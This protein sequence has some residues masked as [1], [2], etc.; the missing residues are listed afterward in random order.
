VK[1]AL[2]MLARDWRAGELRVLALALAVA[3]AAITSV[4]FFADRVGQSLARD[5]HQLLGADLV[6]RADRP[7]PSA[8]AAA[9]ERAGV[10]RAEAINFISMA[11]A[12]ESHL[13]GVKA[14][15]DNYPLR[16]RLRIASAPGM[17]DAPAERGPA[18]GTVWLEERLVSA[19]GAPVG[20]RIRLGRAEF[21]VAAVLTL[22]PER[23]TSFFN[24][25]PRL[26]M[27]IAD[28]PSTALIQT[29]SRVWY[30]LYAAGP[31]ERIK[32]LQQSIK[33]ERGQSLDT[34]E[35]GRPEV[36]SA[37]DR[38]QRFLGLT[39]LLAAILAGVAVA[40]GTRRFVER[41]LDGC[42]VMRCLGA[43]QSQLLGLYALEF[44]IL[45]VA[46][47]AAGCAIGFVAQEAIAATV[48]EVIRAD[49]PPP[50]LLPAVQGFLVGLVLLLGFALPPLVQLRNVP[51]VR[52]M[53]RESGAPKGGTLV[54]YAAGLISLSSLLVWQAG[55]LKLGLTVVGGFA[56]A[57][58]VFFVVAWMFLKAMTGKRA[59]GLMPN[60][61][62]RYGL[63]NLRR[64]ARS[65]AVQ[66]ASLALGLTA[67]LL[68]T[69]TRND[70]VDAWRRSAPPDAPNRF[71]IG[72]Q[73]EQLEPLQAF[74]A[75]HKVPVPDLYP[76]VRGRLIA[77]N[78]KPVSEADYSEER[79]KRLVEREFNLSYMNDLPGHN[80]VVAGK[81]FDPVAK[82]ISVEQGIAE[83]LGWRLGDE[84]TWSVGSDS[85]SARITSLRKLRWDSMKVNFFVV[86]P[87]A[88]LEGFPVSFISA[89]HLG[90]E[91]QPVITELAARFPNVTV[92]DAAA[93]VRQA[94]DVIDQLI[95]A[96]Q[97]VFLFTLAAGLLV[98]YSA[99]VATEDERRREAAVMRVYGASRAQVTGTQRAE[100]LAMGAIAGLLATLGAAAIG[101]VLARRVFELDLPPSLALWIAGPLAGLALLSLNAWLSSRKVL[102]ASPALTLRDSV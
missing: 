7:W 61:M 67:V 53:R 96:V 55:D 80:Q 24:V 32:S 101:Q 44:V 25:A 54:A 87:P 22:E 63:A 60:S 68:L 39:A 85:F 64:H 78:G 16:G 82:E 100:F 89:F 71:L 23:S 81:W 21:E 40:L 42:A 74:F 33:L 34:L 18:T 35:T 102:R 27:N 90:P 20:T 14:V 26:M 98:L 92:I 50:R 45:G 4:A 38:A 65:N 57:V 75:A 30:Y 15:S 29:G 43:T 12:K 13:S 76:M 49:L 19:L 17:P 94:Q 99:L 51:A 95:N 56:A 73:A 47:C 72:V 1:Q 48:A 59:V 69:F 2:R 3:V 88:L 46:A 58:A 52:V 37:V 79:A 97:F 70:L 86:T 5:A 66:I 83:R 28:V 84:L 36:R 6:L 93:A 8:T 11:S 77:V 9:I 41:H 10:Q 91:A 62:L 31:A